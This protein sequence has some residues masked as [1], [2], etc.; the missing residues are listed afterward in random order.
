MCS[1]VCGHR[2]EGVP[3]R[4]YVAVARRPPRG[5]LWY[6]GTKVPRYQGTKVPRYQGTKVPRYQGTKVPRYQGTKVPRLN[7]KLGRE[8]EEVL[9]R[10]SCL[11]T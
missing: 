11:V 5:E 10:M 9:L 6:Q 7:K 8:K 2:S 3:R 1:A 4:P